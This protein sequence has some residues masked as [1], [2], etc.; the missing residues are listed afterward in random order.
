M[1]RRPIVAAL[2]AA[3]LSFALVGC[4][5]DDTPNSAAGASTVSSV[6][7]TL[8]ID[9]QPQKLG[10]DDVECRDILG[11]LTVAAGYTSTPDGA[12]T[13][14]GFTVRLSD[15]PE[16]VV[17]SVLLPKNADGFVPSYDALSGGPAPTVVRDG[18]QYTVEGST[19][20]IAQRADTVKKFTATFVCPED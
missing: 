8:V 1:N 12:I 2:L 13:T 14:D 20:M 3:A 11:P 7:P 6:P 15:S 16:P 5:S 19:G 4:S 17:E 10:S 18:S 9:G